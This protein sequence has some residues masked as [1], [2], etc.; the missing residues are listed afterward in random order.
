[1][2]NNSNDLK[3]AY[4]QDRVLTSAHDEYSKVLILLGYNSINIGYWS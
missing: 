2:N 3:V 4:Q 1:M